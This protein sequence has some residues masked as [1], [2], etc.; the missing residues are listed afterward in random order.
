MNL[1]P[2]G[3]CLSCGTMELRLWHIDYVRFIS[4]CHFTQSSDV[5]VLYNMCVCVLGT[6]TPY[7]FPYYNLPGFIY[8]MC[9]CCVNR[10]IWL[11]GIYTVSTHAFVRYCSIVNLLSLYIRALYKHHQWIRDDIIISKC[12][13][14]ICST[15]VK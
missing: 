4:I 6:N 15:I 13:R 3:L 9:M 1:W 2:D 11:L 10:T 14:L 5:C 12:L 7:H 8:G